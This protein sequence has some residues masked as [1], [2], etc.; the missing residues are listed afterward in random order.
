MKIK[1]LFMEK[2]EELVRKLNEMLDSYSFDLTE[3]DFLIKQIK[4]QFKIDIKVF[5][6][7]FYDERRMELARSNK[8][9]KLE[10]QDFEAAAEFR[11]IERECLKYISIKM[12]YHI[13][14]SQFY[15]EKNHVFYFCLR[16]AKN[17]KILRDYLKK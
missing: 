7:A 11:E 8:L 15:Y 13:E 4:E 3:F 12:E 2:L 17:D 1:N 16:T 14:K 9:T 6:F 5:D 10:Q